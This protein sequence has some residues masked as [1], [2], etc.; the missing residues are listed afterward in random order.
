MLAFMPSCYASAL[1]RTLSPH[2]LLTVA[3][4]CMRVLSHVPTHLDSSGQ[5]VAFGAPMVVWNGDSQAQ[6]STARTPAQAQAQ[7]EAE[8]EAEARL[9]LIRVEH[10]LDPV[11]KLPA[12]AHLYKVR[13]SLPSTDASA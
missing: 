8:A 1:A 5:V 3:R 12:P 10:M 6:A 7:A 2:V 9:P 4:A 13:V 11:V